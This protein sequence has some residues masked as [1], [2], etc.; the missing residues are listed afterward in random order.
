MM[1]VNDNARVVNRP[2]ASLTDDVRVII[3]YYYMFI[4]QAVD[5]ADDHVVDK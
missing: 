5:V 3:Y 4:V 1:V 2:E